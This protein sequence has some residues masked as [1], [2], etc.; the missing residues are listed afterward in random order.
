MKDS[1]VRNNELLDKVGS[2]A[3]SIGLS[4]Y[5]FS[6]HGIEEKVDS[7]KISLPR[8]SNLGDYEKGSQN[9]NSYYK[10]SQSRISGIDF[11]WAIITLME[12]IDVSYKNENF[13]CCE[14]E[15]YVYEVKKWR[16]YIMRALQ[17]IYILKNS[18]HKK[19]VGECQDF[20]KL[21]SFI[22][23][24][25]FLERAKEYNGIVPAWGN[26]DEFYSTVVFA[27]KLPLDED[28]DNL[29]SGSLEKNLD[30]IWY[31]VNIDKSFIK[32]E[33]KELRILKNIPTTGAGKDIW[34]G[35]HKR[36]SLLL[37]ILKKSGNNLTFDKNNSLLNTSIYSYSTNQIVRYTPD[38]YRELFLK[39]CN[40]D[41]FN[42][43][44]LYNLGEYVWF[45]PRIL[46]ASI[47]LWLSQEIERDSNMWRKAVSDSFEL[48]VINLLRRN[49]YIAGEVTKN[50]FWR[51][52]QPGKD[53]LGEQKSSLTGQIDVLARNEKGDIIVLEC[54]SVKPFGNPR[55]VAGKIRNDDDSWR[56]NLAKKVEWV[57]K[58]FKQKVSYSAIVQEGYIYKDPS[59]NNVD[60]PVINFSD[61]ERKII[62]TQ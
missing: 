35:L 15:E 37:T 33:F 10:Y 62:A 56:R 19:H 18:S 58:A 25:L 46:V 36:L 29:L 8:F 57:E 13:S 20:R 26:S 42:L 31:A 23:D 2:D 11:D 39:P 47:L 16:M 51:N 14:E 17:R 52:G 44:P 50:G 48:K 12:L 41:S 32:S 55:N 49:N 34:L 22:V 24:C 54:K 21:S 40:E 45:S 59:E 7:D 28:I 5:R 27:P 60:I 38:S 43:F 53:L 6:R 61:L 9:Y 4:L 3:T 30:T 1:L